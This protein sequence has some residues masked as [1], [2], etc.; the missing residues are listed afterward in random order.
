MTPHSDNAENSTPALDNAFDPVKRDE[1]LAS[2]NRSLPD[3]T[4]FEQISQKTLDGFAIQVLYDACQSTEPVQSSTTEAVWDNRLSLQSI[5]DPTDANLQVLRGLNGGIVSVEVHTDLPDQLSTVLQGVDLRLAPISV[6]AGQAYATAATQLRDMSESLGVH[7]QDCMFSLNADPFGTAL[8]NGG[9][10]TSLPDALLAMAEFSRIAESDYPEF[11][12]VLVDAALHHNAGASPVEELHAAIATAALYLEA[13][14]QAGINP[15]TAKNQISFQLAMDSDV[16]L[17]TAKLRA[18]RRLWQHVST[19]MSKDQAAFGPISIT[20]ETSKR[21]AS[22]LDP[23]NNHLRNVA[24]CA[25][26]AMAG[27]QSIIV[28]PHMHAESEADRELAERVARNLPIILQREAGLLHVS[29]PFAGSYALETLTETLVL[30]AW[31]CLQSMDT[32]ENWLDELQQG[33]WQARLT[34][35][36]KRRS[37]LIEQGQ[38]VMVGVNRYLSPDAQHDL[39]LA[40]AEPVKSS[41]KTPAHRI[42]AL[43]AVRDAQPFE[44][45]T[46][47]AAEGSA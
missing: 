19:L 37:E 24:A 13:M 10:D 20:A 5:E 33:R 17:G 42:P 1:W 21:Q 39:Q 6:R 41:L 28:H 7:A 40:G 36:H 22:R 11:N 4:T 3:E 32:A 27:A 43:R 46:E 2:V 12:V 31:E 35:T 16:L 23:W 29:D 47:N 8:V 14:L 9:L 38:Q 15:G 30:K 25:S 18:L 44:H 26:A 34:D 45:K